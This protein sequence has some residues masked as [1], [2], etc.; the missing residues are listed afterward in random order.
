MNRTPSSPTNALDVLQVVNRATLPELAALLA[1]TADSQ[2]FPCPRCGRRAWAVDA[3]R[4]SCFG[5]R[6]HGTIVDLAHVVAGDAD[7]V[8]ALL[9]AR[10]GA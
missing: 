8:C 9:A 2:N 5:C 1:P 3:W 7:A 6:E 4:W 10:E